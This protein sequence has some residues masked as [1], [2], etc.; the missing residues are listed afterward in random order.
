MD[1]FIGEIRLFGGPYAPRGWNLCDGTLMQ[2]ASNEAL[3]SLIGTTYGGDGQTTFALP[4]LRGRAPVHQGNGNGLS[5]RT[6]GEQ[7]GF[8]TVTITGGQLPAHTHAFNCTTAAAT[9]AAPGPNSTLAT[10]QPSGGSNRAF[11]CPVSVTGTDFELDTLVL[12]Q[13]GGNG[14]HDNMMLSVPLTF[15]IALEGI[16][17]SRN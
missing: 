14:P 4:D 13:T 1:P 11:Y 7:D 16:Y 12:E 10:M 6:L 5:P 3:F 17:P 8:E 15:I 9:D 2:I